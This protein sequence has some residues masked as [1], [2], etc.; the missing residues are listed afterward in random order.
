MNI[1]TLIQTV[2]NLIAAMQAKDYATVFKIVLEILNTFAAS[3]DPAI[4]MAHAEATPEQ[5]AE[6]KAALAELEAC[7]GESA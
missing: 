2:R 6:L 4:K 7:C 5:H 3:Q 1:L